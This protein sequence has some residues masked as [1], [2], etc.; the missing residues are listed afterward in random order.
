MKIAFFLVAMLVSVIG[1]VL[2][3]ASIAVAQQ[4]IV[5]AAQVNGT[6]RSKYGEFKIWALG[7]QRLRVEFSGTYEYRSPYGPMANIGEGSGIAFIE[8]NTAA[9]KPDGVDDECKIVLR[10]TENSLIADQDGICGFGHNVSAAG[11]YRKISG[12]KPKFEN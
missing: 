12:R 10:F 3:P 2:V 9:F 8:G 7:K 6:W 1:Q 4:T 5:T 11:T